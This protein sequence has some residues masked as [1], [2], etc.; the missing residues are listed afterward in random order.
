MIVYLDTEFIERG[1]DKIELISIGLVAENGA[2]YYSVASD[3]WDREHAGD[4]VKQNVLP[5]V[6]E[7]PFRSRQQIAEDIRAFVGVDPEFH[8]YYSS[9]DW[10]LLCQLFG[11]MMDLPK[12]W[13]MFCRDVIQL[14]KHKGNPKLP[15]QPSNE[16]HHA[17]SDA[18]HIKVMHEFL[19]GLP[20][21]D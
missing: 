6:A 4:W 8:G 12:G 21:V 13:P 2:E 20:W 5:F 16:E 17:L 10:V 3:G 1:Y 18:R 7:G 19:R 9:Y 15:K 14:C 11:T